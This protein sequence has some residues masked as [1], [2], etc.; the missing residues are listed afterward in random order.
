MNQPCW[1]DCPAGARGCQLLSPGEGLPAMGLYRAVAHPDAVSLP[2]C[3]LGPPHQSR[4]NRSLQCR[5]GFLQKRVRQE[6]SP[7]FQR[8]QLGGPR[9][10]TAHGGAVLL[11]E[12]PSWD[13]N[14]PLTWQQ[15]PSLC[16]YRKHAAALLA[17]PWWVLCVGGY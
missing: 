5:L 4:L 7:F 11:Q 6:R 2:G 10:S 15:C 3:Q 13:V 8:R 14:L 16:K 1:L 9:L 17:A 12:V